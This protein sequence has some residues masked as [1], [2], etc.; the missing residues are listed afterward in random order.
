MNQTAA[1]LT[2]VLALGYKNEQAMKYFCFLI[3]LMGSISTYAQYPLEKVKVGKAIKI[4]VPENFILMSK[5][6]ARIT[7]SMVQLR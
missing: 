2:I 3:A 6:I 7:S 4:L 1:N 5:A